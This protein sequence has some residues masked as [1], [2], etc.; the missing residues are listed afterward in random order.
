MARQ[1]VFGLGGQRRDQDDRLRLAGGQPPG[2]DQNYKKDT[3]T[4]KDHT[5]HALAGGRPG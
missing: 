1:T 5:V 2:E 4:D 3:G